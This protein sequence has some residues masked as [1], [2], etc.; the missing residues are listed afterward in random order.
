MYA[1]CAQDAQELRIAELAT[2]VGELQQ[3]VDQEPHRGSPAGSPLRAL[4]VASVSAS[5][6]PVL[7]SASHPIHPGAVRELE[8]QAAQLSAENETLK[9]E[10]ESSAQ[11]TQNTISQGKLQAAVQQV[12]EVCIDQQLM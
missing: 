2:K 7:L 6:S 11:G 4:A 8:A 12:C 9:Q 5:A 1:A 10:L 3:M